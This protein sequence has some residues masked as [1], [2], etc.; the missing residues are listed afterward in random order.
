MHIHVAVP[1]A[2]AC[3]AAHICS[4]SDPPPR[5]HRCW[6]ASPQQAP[7]LQPDPTKDWHPTQPGTQTLRAILATQRPPRAHSG[8]PAHH[9]PQCH[10]AAGTAARACR[11]GAAAAVVTA[12]LA[13]MAYSR[14]VG[15][16]T[17]GGPRTRSGRCDGPGEL[18]RPG[19]VRHLGE[20]RGRACLCP[21]AHFPHGSQCGGTHACSSFRSGGLA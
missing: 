21:G 19:R 8:R 4:M 13:V 17:A 15:V 3:A 7:R 18:A 2:D 11:P 14:A 5:K 16:Q 6:S 10:D 20:M 12:V 9:V 1:A